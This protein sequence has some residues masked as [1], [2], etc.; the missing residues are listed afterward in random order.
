MSNYIYRI[1]K[2]NHRIDEIK[3]ILSSHPE[4]HFISL[5][6][7]D[8]SGHDTDTKIPV[9]AFLDDIEDFLKGSVQTDGSSVV[10]PK[11]ATLNDAKIDLV[12]DLDVDWFVDY[13]KDLLDPSTGKYV[14]TLKIPCFLY[15][16]N[17]AVDSRSILKKSIMAIKNN[18]FKHFASNKN[19]CAEYGFEYEDLKDIHVITATELEFWVKTP[20]QEALLD[21]LSTSQ[22]L[23]EQYWKKTEG[24]VRTSLEEALISIEHYGFEPEM[25]HKE[26]GG[27]KASLDE[28]GRHTHIME[29]LE[30]DWKYSTALQTADNELFIKDIIREVFRRNGLDVTFMAKPIDGVAGNG[31][32]IHHSIMAELKNGK[33]I[34]LYAPTCNH[35]MSS[36]G[37]ASI[38]GV[39]KNYEVINPFITSSYTSLKRL[40]P[41]FEAPVSIVASLGSSVDE[42]SRNRTI[43]LGLVRDVKNPM[44]TR[45]ELRSPNPHSNTYLS[46]ASMN[47]GI[48]DGILYAAENERNCDELLKELSKNPNEFFGY[49][50]KDRMYRTEKNVFDD[51]SDSERNEFFGVAPKTVFECMLPLSTDIN[52]KSILKYDDVFNDLI[53]ES[54]AYARLSKWLT[55]LKHRTI[56]TYI[57]EL[58]H[59]TCIH[60]SHYSTEYD[61]NRW[62]D[63]I[64]EKKYLIQSTNSFESLFAK[65]RKA[66]DENHYANVSRLQ[67][68]MDDRINELRKAYD[69]YKMN[70]I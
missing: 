29:Q 68:E 52:K 12:P 38:M 10:L 47:M 18:L 53:L 58:K 35:F 31:K 42:P 1:A 45:F 60:S 27:V 48:L 3:S 36:I 51:F 69:E 5:V 67:L 40:K 11:I 30:I 2:S 32:H 49:L 24:I 33:R 21:E 8:L 54:Y 6:G 13:N 63:I 50:D 23:K 66:V 17:K 37:Y 4:I 57:D 43:L 65:I 34:N 46:M 44:S 16:N 70:L 41:G 55:E 22:V 7:I 20:N 61:E 15:H 19:S 9:K 64:S 39:L 59:M 56:P 26:V 62:N 28:R 25:G 14:G